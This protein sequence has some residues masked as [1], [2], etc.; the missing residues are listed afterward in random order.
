MISIAAGQSNELVCPSLCHIFPKS[1]KKMWKYVYNMYVV[2]KQLILWLVFLCFFKPMI[3]VLEILQK[4][5]KWNTRQVLHWMQS[6]EL[7]SIIIV[8]SWWASG[9]HTI[10]GICVMCVCVWVA[11]VIVWS[12]N[13]A[14]A[15]VLMLCYLILLR[16]PCLILLRNYRQSISTIELTIATLSTRTLPLTRS[17]IPLSM[18]SVRDMECKAVQRHN[19]NNQIHF[20]SMEKRTIQS[21]NLMREKPASHS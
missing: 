1:I 20:I 11:L 4:M 17:R 10:F 19:N 18:L 15:I 13:L 7:V 14:D 16:W 9:F 2:F 8:I 21:D 12:M 5:E 6:N 3:I